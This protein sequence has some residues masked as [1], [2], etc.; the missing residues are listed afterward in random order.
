[1][2]ILSDEA[3]YKL[4]SEH[5]DWGYFDHPPMI[6][7]IVKVSSLFFSGNL[8]IRFL[9]LLLQLFTLLLIWITLDH[10]E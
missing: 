2:E 8:G 7:L 4:Y 5:L 6:A 3:Y 10:R 1:M 9:T